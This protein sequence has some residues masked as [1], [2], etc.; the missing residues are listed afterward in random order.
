MAEVINAVVEKEVISPLIAIFSGCCFR[1]TL[2][3]LPGRP[4]PGSDRPQGEQPEPA[5]PVGAADC[6][7]FFRP[8]VS[9]MI[10]QG[11]I[12]KLYN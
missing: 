1:S 2:F 9:A 6:S 4:E 5:G 8:M 10:I 3:L 12:N 7:G 11:E